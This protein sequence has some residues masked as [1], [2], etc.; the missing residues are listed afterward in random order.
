MSG[1]I[2]DKDERLLSEILQSNTEYKEYFYEIA[3]TRAIGLIPAVEKNK[4]TNYNWLMFRLKK[5]V[6][7]HIYNNR[8]P[9]F[10]RV[11][12]IIVFAVLSGITSYYILHRTSEYDNKSMICE[13]V[14][15]LGSQAKI[16][17]PDGTVVWLNSGSI[18]KYN[19]S[20]GT[21]NR[22]VFLSGE[23]Y[24]DVKKDKSKPFLVNTTKIGIKVLGTV[25]NVSS[26]INDPTIEVNLLEGKV[27]ITALDNKKTTKMSL[28]PNEKIVYNK[29]TRTMI[30]YKTNAAKSALWTTG[31]LCFVDATMEN[32]T[33]NLERK[34]DVQILLETKQ[35]KDEIFSG[36]LDLN[37]PLRLILDY[38]DVD[39]KFEKVQTGKRIVIKDKN[40]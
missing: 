2:S 40:N 36:T 3:K 28:L 6:I 37:Q 11:A 32:I 26:Y 38:I 17:L 9:S 19:N 18:L 15:P 8:F 10:A 13:T 30:S 31:K 16:I 27:D 5:N 39:K 24:F 34:F 12:A 14:V 29:K 35:I 20:Y 4:K 23:G 22:E 33:N 25:F 7:F 1:N 21:K